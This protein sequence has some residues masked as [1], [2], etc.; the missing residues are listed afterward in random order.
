MRLV[1][2]RANGELARRLGYVCD[3]QDYLIAVIRATGEAHGNRW[4]YNVLDVD[5]QDPKR[6]F[7]CF[8]VS[9]PVFDQDE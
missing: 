1:I 8:R 2:G 5:N 4:Y 6:S 3:S 9:V 7:S